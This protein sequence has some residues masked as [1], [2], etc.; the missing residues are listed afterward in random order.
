MFENMIRS[1]WVLVLLFSIHLNALD[2]TD[3]KNIL[4]K[5]PKVEAQL[6]VNKMQTLK[7]S[8]SHKRLTYFE[9]QLEKIKE[10]NIVYGKFTIEEK[11]E[12]LHY[13]K[14]ERNTEKKKLKR[15]SFQ[16]KVSLLKKAIIALGMITAECYAANHLLHM[17]PIK[18]SPIKDV[19]KKRLIQIGCGCNTIGLLG[20][21]G[22]FF[23]DLFKIE[24]K[25]N[26]NTLKI[27]KQ[28]IKDKNL[29]S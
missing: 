25:R 8:I 9:V 23:V 19:I 3:H 21:S 12:L 27:M 18:K 24:S 6:L 14:K 13:I 10:S 29:N 5:A 2:E 4:R 26:V 11:Q 20:L 16:E 28:Q 7:K 17:Q 1:V 22:W 15:F